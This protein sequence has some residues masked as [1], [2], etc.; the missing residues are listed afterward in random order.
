MFRFEE[1]YFRRFPS[2]LSFVV[3]V[4]PRRLVSHLQGSRGQVCLM[5]SHVS[6]FGWIWLAAAIVLM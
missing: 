1:S 4:A 2:L 6:R 3:L 5:I